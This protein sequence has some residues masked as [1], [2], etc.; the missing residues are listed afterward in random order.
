MDRRRFLKVFGVGAGAVAGG[1]LLGKAEAAPEAQE[2]ALFARTPDR[3]LACGC[4]SWD[5]PLGGMTTEWLCEAHRGKAGARD[6]ISGSKFDWFEDRPTQGVS[7]TYCSWR[8]PLTFPLA[9]RGDEPLGPEHLPPV[10]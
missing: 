3:E 1:G 6:F 9:L 2:N 10:F 8:D 4:K 5:G 7:G